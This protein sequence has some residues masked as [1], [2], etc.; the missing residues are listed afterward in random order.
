MRLYQDAVQVEYRQG[1]YSVTVVTSVPWDTERVLRNL[2]CQVAA[3]LSRRFSRSN[4]RILWRTAADI[5]RWP[6][7]FW[8]DLAGFVAIGLCSSAADPLVCFLLTAR[9]NSRAISLRDWI[10]LQFI[11][12]QYSF[13]ISG[14]RV[15]DSNRVRFDVTWSFPSIP[16]CEYFHSNMSR[17]KLWK[18]STIQIFKMVSKPTLFMFR[19]GLSAFISYIFVSVSPF[20]WWIFTIDSCWYS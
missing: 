5:A 17:L 7:P 13:R 20:E 4:L 8:Q 11:K 14:N 16:I 1:T 10:R 9:I 2:P 18:L 12:T 6:C 15:Y 3:R 19:I